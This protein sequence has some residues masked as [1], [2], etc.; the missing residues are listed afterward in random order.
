MIPPLFH[1]QPTANVVR[2]AFCPGR[3]GIRHSFGG[4]FS[5]WSPVSAL[6]PLISFL[7]DT[8]Q[9]LFPS[10]AHILN[11]LNGISP[12][13]PAVP[14]NQSILL[15][16]PFRLSLTCVYHPLRWAQK[17]AGAASIYLSSVE[18]H[19]FRCNLGLAFISQRLPRFTFFA[20]FPKET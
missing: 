9:A 3:R 8:D 6:H 17:Q 7:T 11:A 1:L 18:L 13:P 14:L 2:S 16:T 19:F 15:V 20:S 5:T 12:L 4:F 10:E